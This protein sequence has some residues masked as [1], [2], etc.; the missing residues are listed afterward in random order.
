[1]I[2]ILLSDHHKRIK[3]VASGNLTT[4]ACCPE[5]KDSLLYPNIIQ[6]LIVDSE[7]TDRV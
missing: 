3:D 2:E 7:V 4:C 6:L 5:I 1:M